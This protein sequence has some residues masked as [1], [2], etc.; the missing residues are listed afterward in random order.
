MSATDAPP[1]TRRTAPRWSHVDDC[2]VDGAWTRSAATERLPLVDPATGEEWGSVP[3]CA[4][5]DVDAA[6]AA[7]DRAFRT[8]PWAGTAP[9]ERAALLLRI[10][11][12][13]EAR[14]ADM[15]VT[16]T[17]EN[18][19]P[20]GETRGAAANAAGILRHVAGLAPW[21]EDEDVRPFPA[22]GAE[23]VVRKDPVGPCVL[24]APWNFPI[25]LMVVKLAPALLAGCTVVMKPAPGTS[26][27]IRFVVEACAAAGVPAGVVNLVT[28]G[29]EVGDRLV[30]HPLTAKVAFTG[31]TP[32]GRRIAAA[33]GEL[34]RPVTLELGG[35]SSAIV[36]DD[37]DLGQ[38]SAAL[39]RT[40]L[41]NTGQTCYIATRIL[42]PSARYDEVVDMVTRTVAAA[43]QGDPFDEAT[44][45]GPMASQA[46][47]DVV[48]GYL[49][50][51]HDEG[52]R[53]TTGGRPANTGRGWFIEPTVFADV[54]PDMRIAREEVFGPVVS[55][56]RYDDLDDAV[57]LAND[58]SFGLGGVVFS[59]D[60]V[61][62]QAVAE[63]MDTGSVGVNF[64]SSNHN[65]PFGGRHDSGLGVEYGVEGLSQYVTYKSI[66]RPVG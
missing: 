34:L 4:A 39:L 31:S 50:S 7:A 5:D 46:Q 47:Y 54:T 52:A 45:F 2:F 63:R 24:I 16:N 30:R 42:A 29:G 33:C 17:L 48:R 51:A 13:V 59:S 21:L 32:V 1:S 43:P 18:G 41:R 26:L 23:T 60:P 3:D 53:A 11:D 12:E 55:V 6:L 56:L 15:A 57:A 40:S 38:V 35:K 58:T 19:S 22:G 44:V 61:A 37:A 10:A 20:I 65:A 25:N 14:A 64:F 8:G 62:G 28:G 9:S 49:A 27:S 36:L 66:H